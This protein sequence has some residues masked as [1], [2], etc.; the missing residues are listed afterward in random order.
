MLAA[1]CI[2]M[3]F[4]ISLASYVALTFN[5]LAMSTRN[6]GTQRCLE[7]AEAGIE[8]ALYALNNSDWSGWTVTTA[9]GTTTATAQFTMT[10]AGFVSTSSSPTPLNL[11]NGMNGQVN[12]TVSFGAGSPASLQTLTS[13]GVITLPAGSMTTG[14]NQPTFTRTLSYNGGS[15]GYS[16]APVFVNAIAA[17]SSRITMSSAPTID[18]F[19]SWNTSTHSYQNYST[20]VAGYSAVVASSSTTSATATVNIGNGTLKGYVTG[21]DYFSPG[22]TNW[23]SYSGSAK[24]QGPNTPG[25]TSIDSNRILSTV[26]PYQPVYPMPVPSTLP[27]TLPAAATMGSP[28]PNYLYATCSLGVTNGTIPGVYNA[29]GIYIPAG[30]TV[31]ITGPVVLEVNGPIAVYGAIQLAGNTASLAIYAL[32]GNMTVSGQGITNLNGL[33]LAKRLAIIGPTTPPGYSISITQTTPFYGVIYNPCATVTIG[34]NSTITGSIVGS[35]VSITGSPAIHY[36][37][38]LRS[39]VYDSTHYDPAFTLVQPPVLVPSLLASVP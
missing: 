10:S 37:T 8:Q 28:W 3:V 21:Y 24:L 13:Q 7:V 27:S 19:P 31:T 17:V 1:L 6:V 20:T 39:P 29:S 4:A 25:G 2:A 30:N 12:L 32:G 26:V 36:D 23:F 16:P 22:T 34:G 18:S 33:P 38:S 5:S 14:T 9:A 15:T 11:G 35:R